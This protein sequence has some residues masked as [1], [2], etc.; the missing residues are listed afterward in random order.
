MS[1]DLPD[2]YA[3]YITTELRWGSIVLVRSL[4]TIFR[5]DW[6]ADTRGPCGIA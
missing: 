6:L 5:T 4:R 1:E 3:R 2:A